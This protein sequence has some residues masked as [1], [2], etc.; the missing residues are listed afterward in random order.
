MKD[1]N[2]N[3]RDI[4]NEQIRAN[5]LLVISSSGEQLGVISKKDALNKAY[6]EELD[7]VLISPGAKPPV[8]KIMDYGKFKYEK[9]K[10]DKENKQ[11]QRQ[12]AVNLKLIRVSPT[13]DS[14]DYNTKIKQATKF[15]NKGDKVQFSIR[16]KG[17]M[18]SH[19]E[20]GLEVL[21][22]IIDELKD[23]SVVEQ[24][25]KIDRR[26]MYNTLASNIKK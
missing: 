8:A 15:L 5:E 25:P 19:S 12:K 2:K 22:K 9:Q 3:N 14:H 23:I 7:L 6:E 13:I 11:K 16:F 26:K 18:I 24:R 10:K 4:I 20:L 1:N 17:R 21:N